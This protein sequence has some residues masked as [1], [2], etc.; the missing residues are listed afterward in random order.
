MAPAEG[1]QVRLDEGEV[2]PLSHRLDVV[3]V[4]G[5]SAATDHPA[6]RVRPDERLPQRPPRGRHVEPVHRVV[7][8]AR[9]VL[10]VPRLQARGA[11]L[12]VARD[13]RPAPRTGT[14]RSPGAHRPTRIV[15]RSAPTST[16]ARHGRGPLATTE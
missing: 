15:A 5:R 13:Q 12:L 4:L 16:L 9:V 8:P 11:P 2:R 1:L 6:D 7:L 3:D 10:P 14:P